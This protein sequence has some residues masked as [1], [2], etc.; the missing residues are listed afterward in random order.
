MQAFGRGGCIWTA[1]RQRIVSE[2]LLVHVQQLI[3]RQP[4]DSG[5]Y[6]CTWITPSNLDQVYCSTNG[7]FGF[8]GNPKDTIRKTLLFH[9]R[10][11]RREGV[12]G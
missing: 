4:Y 10:G 5:A 7:L 3:E 2:L 11:L 9:D 1:A 12:S 6:L 8:W